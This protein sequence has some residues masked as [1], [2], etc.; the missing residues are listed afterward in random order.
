MC[1][2]VEMKFVGTKKRINVYNGNG[3][4]VPNMK[5]VWNF[6]LAYLLRILN[7]SFTKF[8]TVL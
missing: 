7:V 1:D 5:N 4:S 6:E 2:Q 3:V 8:K